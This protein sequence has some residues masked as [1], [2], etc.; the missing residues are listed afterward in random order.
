MFDRSLAA[1]LA[2]GVIILGVVCIALIL[3]V[4]LLPWVWLALGAI[5]EGAL[6]YYE[7]V[8]S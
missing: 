2:A 1:G 5:G 3:G 8:V 7:W 6:R 4:I